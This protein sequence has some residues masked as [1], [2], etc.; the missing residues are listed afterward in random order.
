VPAATT[1]E[2]VLV[3]DGVAAA[4]QEVTVAVVEAAV[5]VAEEDVEAVEAATDNLSQSKRKAT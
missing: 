2:A 4:I 1:A 5:A 3:E